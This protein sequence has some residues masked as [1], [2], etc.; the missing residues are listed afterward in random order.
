MHLT[1]RIVVFCWSILA[2]VIIGKD[3]IR[4][5]TATRDGMNISGPASWYLM[6][7]L[8]A[9]AVFGIWIS[10]FYRKRGNNPNESTAPLES[11]PDTLVSQF[12]GLTRARKYIVV[13]L[14]TKTIRFVNCHTRQ[15]FLAIP[16]SDF[17]CPLDHILDIRQFTDRGGDTSLTIVT[18]TGSAHVPSTATNYERL[19]TLLSGIREFTPLGPAVDHVLKGFVFVGAALAGICLGAAVAP[20]SSSISILG[21][22]VLTGAFIGV[23]LVSLLIHSVDRLF[24]RR[25][26]VPIG[27]A[28][29]GGCIGLIAASTLAPATGWSGAIS[30]LVI[31]GGS[32]AGLVLAIVIQKGWKRP[33]K[34]RQDTQ[35]QHDH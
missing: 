14:A 25:I 32:L 3:I 10:V 12:W 28:V 26:V 2:L 11:E 15:K 19:R 5:S 20:R 21:T 4:G 22:F 34:K 27:F 17:V 8:G 29:L 6:C 23:G 13:N 1:G 9:A 18:E 33:G 7:V 31:G 16:E 24:G 35:H 30:G